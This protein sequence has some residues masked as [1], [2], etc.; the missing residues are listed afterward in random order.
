MGKYDDIIGLPHHRSAYR[1]AMPAENRAAQFAPFAA[2][3]GHDEA[4]A[5][6]ARLTD[7]RR[8][9][10]DEEKERLGRHIERAYRSGASVEIT[11][12]QADRTKEGGEYV[13]VESAVVKVDEVERSLTL[14]SGRTI[15]FDDILSIV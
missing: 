6:S 15:A 10:S 1:P 14:A 3:T 4:I 11:Y 13:K 9:L 12:F 7:A 8:E 2:L 5:E